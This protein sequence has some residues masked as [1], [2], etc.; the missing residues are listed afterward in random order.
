L[1]N[2]GL[3]KGDVVALVAPNYPDTVL[4]FLGSSAGGLVITTV[5]PQYTVGKSLYVILNVLFYLRFT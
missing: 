2:I 1:R 5:N 4:G 3:K